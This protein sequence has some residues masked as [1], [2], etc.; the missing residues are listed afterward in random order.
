MNQIDLVAA[1]AENADMTKAKAAEAVEA[2]LGAIEAALKQ[3]DDVRLVGFG[4]FTKAT[5]K[6]GTARNP[7]TGE[8]VAV[9]ESTTVRFKPGK[10]LKDGVA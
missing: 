7:R 6:A 3:G 5:R 10:G 8:T 1:V 4:T 9:P 2:V